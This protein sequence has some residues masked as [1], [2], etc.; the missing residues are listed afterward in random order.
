MRGAGTFALEKGA[1]VV[2]RAQRMFVLKDNTPFRGT[3]S[4]A[5]LKNAL[6]VDFLTN[7]DLLYVCF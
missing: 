3:L 1:G 7:F 5:V 6:R 4:S 2:K